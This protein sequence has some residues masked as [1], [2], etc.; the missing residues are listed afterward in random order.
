MNWDRPIRPAFAFCLL[1]ALGSSPSPAY[2]GGTRLAAP[3]SLD[4]LSAQAVGDQVTVRAVDGRRAVMDVGPGVRLQGLAELRQGWLLAATVQSEGRQRARLILHRA[5]TDY[6]LPTLPDSN[7]QI[8]DRPMPLVQDGQ[9][10]GVAWLEGPNYRSLTVR[11]ADWNDTGWDLAETVARPVHGSQMALSAVVLA[12]G[13]PLIVWSRFD[14]HDDEIVWSRR[15]G[16]RWTP[17]ARI[18]PDNTQPD[19]TPTLL[20]TPGGG[21]MVAWLSLIDGNYRALVSCFS[22]QD[23]SS[24]TMLSGLGAGDP[25]LLDRQGPVLLYHTVEPASWVVARLR[26]TDGAAVAYARQPRVLREE[27]VLEFSPT[28]VRFR[29]ADVG[30]EA[31]VPWKSSR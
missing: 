1:L 2:V 9:L 4:Q 8:E 19:V 10:R 11:V 27:P 7:A 22:G 26:S 6:V 23:W 14:G 30:V 18:Q 15:I 3:V 16:G 31:S 17:P 25:I 21:A 29:W 5:G 13:T 20:A 12:D 24:P 28:S